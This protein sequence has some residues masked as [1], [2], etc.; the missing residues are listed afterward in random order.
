LSLAQPRD[1]LVYHPVELVG[2]LRLRKTGPT[3]QPGGKVGFVH[4]ALKI[5]LHPKTL[6][7]VVGK[8]VSPNQ[9]H[10]K[11]LCIF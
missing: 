9:Q 8:Y 11:F 5:A 10:T 1:D 6:M 3:G 7:M 2:G 4:C